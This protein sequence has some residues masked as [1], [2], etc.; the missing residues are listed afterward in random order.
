MIGAADRSIRA[1]AWN[2]R[3]LRMIERA[4][5]DNDGCVP[6]RFRDILESNQKRAV[7]AAD[8]LHFPPVRTDAV[9]TRERSQVRSVL[10]SQQVAT[11][12]L[13]RCRAG[14]RQKAMRR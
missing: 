9:A 1:Q 14:H 2:R 4:G 6:H 11:G 7:V 10:R 12:C 5:A 13:R 3:H 8:A